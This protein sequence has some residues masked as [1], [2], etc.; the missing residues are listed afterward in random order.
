MV[1]PGVVDGGRNPSHVL[2][3]LDLEAVDV[4]LADV[5]IQSG[6]VRKPDGVDEVLEPGQEDRSGRVEEAVVGRAELKARPGLGEQVRVAGAQGV[7]GPHRGEAGF[8]GKRKVE[9]QVFR[10]VNLTPTSGLREVLFSPSL[11][12]SI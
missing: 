2:L 9:V 7:K 3:E 6:A 11:Y 4:G 12:L 8:P 5:V 1:E 10:G